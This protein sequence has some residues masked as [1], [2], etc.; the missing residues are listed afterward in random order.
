MI[1]ML[2]NKRQWRCHVDQSNRYN[3]CID[4]KWILKA[5][6]LGTV[7]LHLM[8]QYCLYISNHIVEAVVS[9]FGILHS[10]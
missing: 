4:V 1:T 9:K 2:S 7:N 5:I 3:D 6:E 10:A 8:L